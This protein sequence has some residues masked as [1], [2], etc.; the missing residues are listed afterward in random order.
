MIELVLIITA[1]SLTAIGYS[2][3]RA[4]VAVAGAFAWLLFGLQNYQ[5]S[6]TTWDMYYGLFW[7][8][9]GTFLAITV[10]SIWI[11]IQEQNEKAI[12]IDKEEK[13]ERKEL[14]NEATENGEIHPIDKLRIK[15][16]MAPSEARAIKK[17]NRR[18]GWR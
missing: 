17:Q 10:D 9:L 6:I 15:H 2:V 16:G 8:S 13:I 18:L 1:V 3:K 5:L 11:L 7:F 12:E 14:V 4:V